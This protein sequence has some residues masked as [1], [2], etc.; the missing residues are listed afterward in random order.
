MFLPLRP[1]QPAPLQEEMK[2][3]KLDHFKLF[4]VIPHPATRRAENRM[5]SERGEWFIAISTG[6]GLY[7][8]L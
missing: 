2:L 5:I 3:G 4:P 7:F 6:S 8:H 1:N